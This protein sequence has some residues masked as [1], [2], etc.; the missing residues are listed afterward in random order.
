MA[1]AV[2]YDLEL[3]LALNRE[4]ADRPIHPAPP[5]IA[6][7][8]ARRAR[9]EGIATKIAKRLK[10]YG[11]V[12]GKRVLDFGCGRGDLAIAIAEHAGAASVVGVDI[13]PR[14][15]WE[16]STAPRV[17]FRELDL[18]DEQQAGSLADEFD[19]IVS[20][21]VLEHVVH[22]HAALRGLRTVLR[23]GGHM[24]LSANLHRGPLAS[25]RYRE[26]FF[27]WPHLLFS[28]RV[29]EQ[30]YEHNGWEPQRPSWVNRLTHLHY[31]EWFAELGLDVLR[32]SFSTSPIDE[33]F[34]TRFED[35][36]SRYPRGDLEK[37]FMKVV[38]RLPEPKRDGRWAPIRRTMRSKD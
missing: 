36:L 35:I 15:E 1:S 23:P 30:F 20:N 19:V 38:L 16:E 14:P 32:E 4:Y 12:A 3:F 10:P 13:R 18:S 37:D 22:P 24:W 2:E 27:P 34:Y 9:F 6:D 5:P 25:H 17:T 31:R 26:V 11:G 7:A 33:A 28:D 8:G 29:F 21:S